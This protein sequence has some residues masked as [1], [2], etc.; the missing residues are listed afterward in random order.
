M[1]QRQGALRL[2]AAGEYSRRAPDVECPPPQSYEMWHALK[3][4]GVP[5]EMVVYPGEGHMFK[6]SGHKRDLFERAIA[7]FDKY[8]R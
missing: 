4:L 6:D 1:G 5:T 3:T 8:L 2:P 7:W